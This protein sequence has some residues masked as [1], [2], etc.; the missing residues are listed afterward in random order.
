MASKKS[1]L[2]LPVVRENSDGMEF[3]GSGCTILDAA[4]GGGWAERRISNILGE[5]STGKTLLGIEAEANFKRK[6]PTG[7][8]IHIDTEAAFDP[9]YAESLGLDTESV[10][11]YDA[12]ATVEEIGALFEGIF[13]ERSASDSNEPCLIVL[14][15]VDALTCEAEQSRSMT[16]GTFGTEKPKLLSQ[17]FRRYVRLLSSCN[18]TLMIMS[19]VRANLNAGPFGKQT[20][21]SGGKALKFYCSQQVELQHQKQIKRTRGSVERVVGNLVQAQTLKN[22]CGPSFRKVKFPLVFSYGIDDV[23]ASL[24]FLVEAGR[25]KL[26]G[27]DKDTQAAAGLLVKKINAL[28]GAEYAEHVA[29]VN[30]A[31]VAAWREIEGDFAPTRKKYGEEA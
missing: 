5:S 27:L 14:D 4:L 15:S 6:Y 24:N 7:R 11:L 29:K 22:R 31:A 28:D 26:A 25:G 9:D 8:I 17:L 16:D 21:T 23:A 18:V 10:E 3:I 1:T 2:P 12:F 19:Q 13:S 30:E 20:V